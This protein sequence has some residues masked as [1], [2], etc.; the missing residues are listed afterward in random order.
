MEEAGEDGFASG[1]G[2]LMK[3]PF[4]RCP[5]ELRKG[6]PEARFGFVQFSLADQ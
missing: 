1:R 6:L 5:I 3:D 4:G 2:I